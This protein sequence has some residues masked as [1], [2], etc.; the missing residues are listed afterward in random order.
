LMFPIITYKGIF[1]RGGHKGLPIGVQ[2]DLTFLA[3]AEPVEAIETANVS[4]TGCCCSVRLPG[5][6]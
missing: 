6:D 4:A 1:K 5:P 3:G 2:Q